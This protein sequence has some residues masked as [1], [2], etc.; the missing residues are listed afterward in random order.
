[1]A[2]R[3]LD[4]ADDSIEDLVKLTC[5]HEDEL[6]TGDHSVLSE[7]VVWMRAFLGRPLTSCIAMLAQ[8]RRALSVG[9]RLV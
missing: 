6:S 4:P 2:A 8:A 5:Q 1:M 7:L 9:R 3:L